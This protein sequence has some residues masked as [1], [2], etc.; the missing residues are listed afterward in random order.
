MGVV[1][2]ISEIKNLF[3][4][5]WV[6][7]GNPQNDTNGIDVLS[8]I[9]LYHSKDKKEVCYIGRDKTEGYEKITLIYTGNFKPSVRKLTGIFR[10]IET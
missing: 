5:E 7:L 9:P 3:P 1:V 8:G 6:L 2:N 4:D 10:R